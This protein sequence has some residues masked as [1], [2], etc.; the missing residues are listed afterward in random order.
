M[1]DTELERQLRCLPTSQARDRVIALG[2]GSRNTPKGKC[3]QR[4]VEHFQVVP[5]SIVPVEAPKIPMKAYRRMLSLLDHL[6]FE[7][8]NPPVAQ[9]VGRLRAPPA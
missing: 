8:I 7:L 5:R 3:I 9:K 6:P 1:G 4:L 2:L